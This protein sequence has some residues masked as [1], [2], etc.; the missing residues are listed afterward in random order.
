VLSTLITV[1]LFN[2]LR[3]RI[4]R[5]I[6]R[7]F[8]REKVDLAQALTEFSRE[9]RSIIELPELLDRLIHRMIDLWHIAHGAVYLRGADGQFHLEHADGLPEGTGSQLPTSRALLD[10]LAANQPV[11]QP[12]D[13]AFPL[14]IPLNASGVEGSSLIGVLALG[15]RLSGEGYS[16]G[17]QLLLSGM[18]DQVGGAIN[19]ARLLENKRQLAELLGTVI[20]IGV[21]LS[22]EKDFNQ[23]MESILAEEQTLCNADAGSLY[24]RVEDE[25]QFVFVRN[26]SLRL[27]QGD[28]TGDAI[29]FPPLPMYID[30]RP[31]HQN[32]ATHT[33]LTGKS[34]QIPDAYNASEFDFSGTRRF[35][36]ETGYHSTSFLCVPLKNER[37]DVT[38]VLQLINARHPITGEVVPF[39]QELMTVVESLSSLAS[40]ALGNYIREQALRAEIHK[41]RI[42]IDRSKQ[43]EQV[44][45]I[46]ET[47]YFQ[48]LKDKLE[49]IRKRQPRRD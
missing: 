21:M 48:M 25:L 40:V 38:G 37:G 26:Q 39:K 4:Q 45:E 28:A 29:L 41:L 32:V 43:A 14:L 12:G 2:P 30:G 15:P 36:G 22:S 49:D 34:V 10:K 9:I 7:R 19:V 23:L 5:F 16:S 42:E 20:D 24:L 13:P 6:D 3:Q 47:E 11:M 17:D 1:A 35:D 8:Y 33:A 44:A 31:N 27:T 18:A 46:T